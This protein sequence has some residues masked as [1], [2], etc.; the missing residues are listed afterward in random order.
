[1]P[2]RTVHLPCPYDPGT[3]PVPRD[4]RNDPRGRPGSCRGS[5]GRHPVP[6]GRNWNHT[7]PAT[8]F[9][10]P[11]SIPIRR[12]PMTSSSYGWR[13]R[14]GK[15]ASGPMAA[16]A[17]AI[18]WAGVEAMQEAGASFG[19]IDNGGDIAHVLRP[20]GQG[21]GPCRGG[22]TLRPGR[23]H[24]PAAGPDPRDL[25]VLGYGRPVHIVR[26][27][28]CGHDLLARCCACRCLG[29]RGLQCDPAGRPVGA[30]TDRP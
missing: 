12:T 26:H 22:G 30:R 7:L 6:P 14:H 15:P 18:A 1:M 28:R 16:V 5:E 27:C 9:L 2:A 23:V 20:P 29:D 11:P 17:G 3:V 4:Y 25:H 19:V 21:R 13:R 10:L 24:R 8:R